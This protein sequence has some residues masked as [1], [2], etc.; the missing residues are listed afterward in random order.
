MGYRVAVLGAA[1]AVGREIV[2]ALEERAFPVDELRLLA[3]ER[4]QGE[5]LEFAGADHTVK[6]ASAELFKGVQL[7][8]FS[9]N[10]RASR[11]WASAAAQAGAIAVD[12]SSAFRL[13]AAVPLVVPE[14]NPDACAGARTRGVVASPSSPAIAL[15]LALQPLHRASPV[16]RAVVT[17]FQ[18]A[19]GVGRKGVSELEKQIADLMNLREA[20]ARVFP[21]RVA[22]NVVPQVGTFTERGSTDEE[23]GIGLELQKLLGAPGLRV[24]ATALRV[25]VYFGHGA[26][27]NL[28]TE[29]KLTAAEARE[30]LKE[31]PGVKLLDDP[32][33]GIYPM[34]MLAV[35]D[36][37]AHVGRI[38]DDASQESGLDLFVCIDNLRKGAALN[39]VQIAELLR[40]R[41]LL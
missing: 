34:P 26:S 22:F 19:S 1:G 21:H 27:A 20:R 37:C 35:G 38:R 4:D 23:E 39:A 13:D 14:V 7:A 3:G 9:P 16:T 12:T 33:R 6:A 29:R 11:L 5:H 15:A 8:F 40:D 25:P 2:A 18:A 10:S 24:S 28:A 31:A 17:T 30:L 32:A 36:A 41:G